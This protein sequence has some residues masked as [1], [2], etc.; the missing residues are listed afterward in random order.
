MGL[1]HQAGFAK[2][3]DRRGLLAVGILGTIA[4]L[5]LRAWYRAWSASAVGKL[6]LHG[7][8]G[9]FLPSLPSVDW[10]AAEAA[11]EAAVKG[12]YL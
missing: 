3:E 10:G 9:G 8:P 2:D 12:I 1:P 7:D 5:R 6:V 4:Y 11:A